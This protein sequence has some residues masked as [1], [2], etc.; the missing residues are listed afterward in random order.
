MTAAVVDVHS[1]GLRQLER[2][3]RL[4]EV[5]SSGPR[6]RRTAVHKSL[7]QLFGEARLRSQTFSGAN[8]FAS[9]SSLPR[10][11]Q[12]PQAQRLERD[13]ADFTLVPQAAPGAALPRADAE[14]P[15]LGLQ[16]FFGLR[17]ERVIVETVE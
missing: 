4:V 15:S 6:S 8:A 5:G 14:Q 16:E 13:I 10:L 7:E 1:E 17:H 12:T 9:T 3:E 11:L 2:A